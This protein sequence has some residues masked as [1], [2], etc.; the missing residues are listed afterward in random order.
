MCGQG[1]PAGIIQLHFPRVVGK[2]SQ[3]RLL[4]RGRRPGIHEEALTGRNLLLKGRRKQ[5]PQQKTPGYCA[6]IEFSTFKND[7]QKKANAEVWC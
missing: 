6:E 3:R 7:L 2:G 1:D 4:R 5:F